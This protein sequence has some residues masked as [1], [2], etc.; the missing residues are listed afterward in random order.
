LGSTPGCDVD[1]VQGID[2]FRFEVLKFERIDAAHSCS[3]ARGYWWSAT[4]DVEF[5]NAES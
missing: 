3:D 2:S 4:A 1:F 5:F